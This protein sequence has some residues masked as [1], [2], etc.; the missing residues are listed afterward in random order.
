[1][2]VQLVDGAKEATQ[3]AFKGTMIELFTFSFFWQAVLHIF[4]GQ[5]WVLQNA[6]VALIGL[7]QV[8]PAPIDYYL[9]TLIS[10]VHL[11]MFDAESFSD[12]I[13]KFSK[14]EPYNAQIE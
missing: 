9:G 3:T 7:G 8:V 11:D 6:L 4:L 1:M 13:F 10:I 2:F 5:I 12:S 14:T